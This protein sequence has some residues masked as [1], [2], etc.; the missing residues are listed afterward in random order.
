[1]MLRISAGRR[2]KGDV[3]AIVDSGEFGSEFSIDVLGVFES[4]G[5]SFRL[6]LEN[7]CEIC[8]F[9]DV[10]IGLITGRKVIGDVNERQA[11]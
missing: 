5:G 3:S 8:I 6:V 10:A 9:T 7:N 2:R 4:D 1:M 11:A